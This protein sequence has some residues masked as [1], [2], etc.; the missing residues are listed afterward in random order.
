VPVDIP[1]KYKITVYC[2]GV[3]LLRIAVNC[4][5]CCVYRSHT[6]TNCYTIRN[7]SCRVNIQTVELR[8]VKFRTFNTLVM[9]PTKR[10]HQ[11][12]INSTDT[13]RHGGPGRSVGIAARYGL[14][15]PR[16]ESALVQT[17]TA[18]H[19]TPCTMDTGSLP[20]VQR[21]GRGVDQPPQLARRVKKG[22]S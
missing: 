21:P 10:T 9:L 17:D 7:G 4:T 5:G 15:G 12:Y 13:M 6:H 8:A 14:D 20:G 16:I 1:V 3:C 19:P 11:M 22:Y 2:S 18:A